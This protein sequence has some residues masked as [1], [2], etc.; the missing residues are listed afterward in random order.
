MKTLLREAIETRD[1]EPMP[2]LEALAFFRSLLPMLGVDPHRWWTDLRRRAFTLARAT[3]E[4]ML[5]RVQDILRGRLETGERISAAPEEI[6]RTLDLMGAG[7]LPGGYGENVVRTNLMDAFN[8][9]LQHEL[10]QVQDTFPVWT[11]SNPNDSRSRPEHAARNG[12]HYPSSV[13]FTAVRGTEA[14]DVCQCRCVP[15]PRD[16]WSWAEMKARGARIADGYADP[17]EV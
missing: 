9:G 15:I 16:K 11:Y 3:N 4:E 17:T 6:E 2:P 1:L 7:P 8:E 14:K 13:P 12:L 10:N 5:S